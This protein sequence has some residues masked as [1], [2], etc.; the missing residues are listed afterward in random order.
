MRQQL[1]GFRHISAS[2]DRP[3]PR[4]C[5]AIY[6]AMDAVMRGQ[7]HAKT[8]LDVACWDIAGKAAN[9]PVY[10]LLGGQQAWQ[11]TRQFR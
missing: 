2:I 3:D 9:L 11:K 4:A 6:G 1:S 8:A 10:T 5:D 7:R